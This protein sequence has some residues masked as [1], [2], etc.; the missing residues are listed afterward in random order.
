MEGTLN[1]LLMFGMF[2]LLCL[3]LL[4]FYFFLYGVSQW[5]E[6]IKHRW[7]YIQYRSRLARSMSYQNLT[8]ILRQMEEESKYNQ[9]L[10]PLILKAK[11]MLKFKLIGTF[12]VRLV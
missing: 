4:F 11:C 6:D 5:G 3:L 2:A 7:K 8:D 10:S 12:S 1:V 9:F